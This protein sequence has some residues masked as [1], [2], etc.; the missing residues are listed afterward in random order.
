MSK[1]DG[2]FIS[3][4]DVEPALDVTSS[5]GEFKIKVFLNGVEQG[6][7]TD[8]GPPEYW[9]TVTPRQVDGTTWTQVAYGGFTYLKKS[10]NNY[11]SY[12]SNNVVFSNGLKM[13]G[14][15]VAAKWQ[16]SGKNLKC[17]DNNSLVGKEGDSFYLDNKNIVE[18]EFVPL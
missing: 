1:G 9:I 13:R 12:R 18:V 15:D 3:N 4:S 2:D 7:F 11:L 16:L 17:L 6:W 5:V 8:V 14:W 10:T